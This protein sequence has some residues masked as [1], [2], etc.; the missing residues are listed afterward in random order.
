MASLFKPLNRCFVALRQANNLGM[1]STVQQRFNSTNKPTT[2]GLETPIE[3]KPVD[4]TADP[5]ET[6][7][8]R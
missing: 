8:F 5:K 7:K 2:G 3:K 1:I 6:C 4:P